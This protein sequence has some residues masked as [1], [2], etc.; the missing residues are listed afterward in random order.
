[1]FTHLFCVCH[2]FRVTREGANIN[3]PVAN[4]IISV[5]PSVMS[6]VEHTF[7]AQLDPETLKQLRML[8]NNLNMMMSQVKD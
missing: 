2:C 3:I 6:S 8:Q 7:M 1:M 5:L 4:G